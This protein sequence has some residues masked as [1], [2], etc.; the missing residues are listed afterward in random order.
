MKFYFVLQISTLSN[1]PL[2]RKANIEDYLTIFTTVYICQHNFGDYCE[3]TEDLQEKKTQKI[4]LSITR[5]IS[6]LRPAFF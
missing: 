4:V 3:I 1:C 2:S 6:A 5:K